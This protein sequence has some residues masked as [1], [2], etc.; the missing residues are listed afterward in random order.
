VVSAALTRLELTTDRRAALVPLIE[1]RMRTGLGNGD[2][3]RT[4]TAGIE[5]YARELIRV[6]ATRETDF[7]EF[8]TFDLSMDEPA[9]TAVADVRGGIGATDALMTQ[10]L[11]VS[12][13]VRIERNPGLVEAFMGRALDMIAALERAGRWSDVIATVEGYGLL[14]EELRT[15]RPDV[16]D[17][18]TKALSDYCTSPRLVALA[19]LYDRD[20]EGRAT[21]ENLARA[22]GAMLV[23]GVIAL[24]N[25]GPHQAKARTLT[26]LLC[27]LAATLSTALVTHL[28][29]CSPAAAR[30]VAKVLGHAGAGVEI[31]L[32]R[33]TEH[34]DLQVARE[35]IR[36]LARIGTPTAAGLIARQIRDGRGE[37]PSA[38]EDALWH[39]P[40]AQIA[41]QVRELLRSREFV[42]AHPHTAA[43]LLDRAAQM[44]VSGLG[45]VLTNIERLRFRFWKP[46]LV[47]VARKAREL[48]SR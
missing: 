28:D 7:S 31:Y 30:L 11:C 34:S 25:H 26:P 32:G 19:D 21:V 36:A 3:A 39:V 24:M 44:K 46:S 48:R 40:P 29:S 8:A 41:T 6:E 38:A 33:L 13:L 1:E 5:R 43:R 15:R 23:P 45:E 16:A 17:A 12:Q 20:A 37:L 47:H 22:L 27:E 10:L 4:G 14:G 2:G 35:A 18:I 9:R 42:C